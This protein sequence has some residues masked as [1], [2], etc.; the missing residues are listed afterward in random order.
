MYLLRVE[1]RTWL[2]LF[3]IR[4]VTYDVFGDYLEVRKVEAALLIHMP[5]VKET[6]VFKVSEYGMRCAKPIGSFAA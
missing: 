5:S 1:F 2:N 6:K 4:K 3:G